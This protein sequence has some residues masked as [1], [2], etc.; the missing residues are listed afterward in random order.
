MNIQSRLS[1]STS[2]FL[3][4]RSSASFRVHKVHRCWV[5]SAGF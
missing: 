5:D 1:T 3:L 2:A 4:K